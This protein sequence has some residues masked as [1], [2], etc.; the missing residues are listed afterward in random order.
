MVSGGS[1]LAEGAVAHST[2]RLGRFT[3]RL[4]FAITKVIDNQVVEW[5]ATLPYRLINLRGNFVSTPHS[6]ATAVRAT[7][8]YGWA[9]PI[10]GSLLC[11]FVEQFILKRAVVARHMHEEGL[12]LKRAVEQQRRDRGR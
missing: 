7:T 4:T 2:E 6:E 5:R 3:L 11:W 9:L 10:L 8:Q 12:Y 1:Q